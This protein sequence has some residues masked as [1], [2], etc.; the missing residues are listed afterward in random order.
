[1]KNWNKKRFLIVLLAA[2]TIVAVPSCRNASQAKKAAEVAKKLSGK[3]VKAS[4]K[5]K[6][7]LQYG[8]D[9]VRN[10]DFEKVSCTA[11]GGDG[12]DYWGRTC[13][14]CEGHGYVYKIKAK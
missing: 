1:M 12:Q 7:V 4:K 11:C 9:V 5:S 2:F 13:E 6:V 8:D 3:I 10:L 14:E